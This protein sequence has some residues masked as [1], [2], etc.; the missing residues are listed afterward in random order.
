LRPPNSYLRNNFLPTPAP[1]FALRHRRL[2]KE[3]AMEEEPFNTEYDLLDPEIVEH[4]IE[5]LETI[6]AQHPQQRCDAP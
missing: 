6:D 2:R 1:A 3:F 5:L 4:L